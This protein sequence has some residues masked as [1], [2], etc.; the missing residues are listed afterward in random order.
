M[1]YTR[2]F[3]YKNRGGFT[4]ISASAETMELAEMACLD[5]AM[6]KGSG[7]KPPRW[8]MFWR[9]KEMLI[10][11]RIKRLKNESNTTMEN[12]TD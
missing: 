10:I 11:N 9:Y 1:I 4:T 3:T 6:S 7:Y 2:H 12:K 8:W 5:S